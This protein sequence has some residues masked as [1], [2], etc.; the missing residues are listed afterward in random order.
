[1][2]QANVEIV[3]RGIEAVNRKPKPDWAT[4]NEAYHPDHECGLG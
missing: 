4:I 3:R 1:M 2:S